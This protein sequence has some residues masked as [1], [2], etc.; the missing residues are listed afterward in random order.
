MDKNYTVQLEPLIDRLSEVRSAVLDVETEHHQLLSQSHPNFQYSTLNFLR[1]LKFRAFDLRE[2]QQSLSVLGISSLSHAERQVLANIENILYLLSAIKDIPFKG[3]YF[4]GE[5]PVNFIESAN[6]LQENTYRLFGNH[7]GK[8]AVMV[9]LPNEATNPAYVKMLLK[10]GMNVARINCSHDDEL[11]WMKMVEN[12]KSV[13]AEID[14]PCSIY[15]DLSGPKIR[16][17]SIKALKKNRIN[18]GDALIR[19]GDTIYLL[20]DL[21]SHFAHEL[22]KKKKTRLTCTLPSIIND[23]QVEEYIWFDDGKIGGVIEQKENWGLKIRITQAGPT[24]SRLKAEKGINLPSTQL[25]LPSLTDEDIQNLDFIVKFA[26]IVGFSFVRKVEDVVLLQKE[27]AKRN[28]SDIGVVLKIENREAFL[29]LPSLILK[30]LESPTVGIMTARGDLAVELGAE[31]LS[32]VQEQI[33][34][35]CEAAL[36]PNIWATQVLET[37]AKTGI[38]SRAEITDAAMSVRAECV[39]LNK[40]P[41][42]DKALKTLNDILFRMEQHQFK[43]LV[44]LRKLHVADEFWSQLK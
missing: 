37:L 35:L 9:T 19:E 14:K 34:W 5:H 26:D 4:F 27:L 8:M 3:K 25:N 10:N 18:K 40:G 44:T 6:R 20:N 16:T 41:Y 17:E 15:A 1:Y 39:M 24:G 12:V 28:R 22:K 7:I 30:L 13:S 32:E 31:R 11:V 21:G 38:P 33:M 43:K 42:I 2:I 29:N 23:A 36:I